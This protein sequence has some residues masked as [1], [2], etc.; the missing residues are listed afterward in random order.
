MATFL[1]AI[2]P[3]AAHRAA[4]NLTFSSGLLLVTQAAMLLVSSSLKFGIC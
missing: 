1:S 4:Q 3:A 2:S